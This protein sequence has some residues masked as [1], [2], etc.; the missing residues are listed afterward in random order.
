MDADS[1]RSLTRGCALVE[2]AQEARKYRPVQVEEQVRI[3]WA[4]STGPGTKGRSRT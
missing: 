3:L 2:L 4:G 1:G